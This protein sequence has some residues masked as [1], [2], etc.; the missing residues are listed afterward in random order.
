ML[1][2]NIVKNQRNWSP[3][4]AFNRDVDRFF[5]DFWGIPSTKSLQDVERE[6][7]PAC[8]VE[9]ATDHYLLT[10]EMAGVPKD[11]IKIE[12]IGNEL[13]I[14]GERQHKTKNQEEGQWYSERYYGKFQRAFSLPQEVE[15]GKVEAN[16]QDGILRVY[17][18]KAEATKPRQIKIGQGSAGTGFFGKL[19]GQSPKKEEEA[20]NATTE[21]KSERVA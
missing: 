19:L 2:Y 17:L 15:V 8:D 12:T 1:N 18:P 20:M 7:R 13:I 10:L 6:W 21:K 3:L 11:E 9:E 14:S 4:S 16:Y 5:D